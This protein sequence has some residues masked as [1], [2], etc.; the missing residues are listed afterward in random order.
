MNPNQTDAYKYLGLAQQARKAGDKRLARQHAE[1]AARLAPELEDVWLMMGA[2]ASPRASVVFMEK[3]LQIN[4][5]SERVRQGLHWAVER[6]KN[7]PPPK[8][9]PVHLAPAPDPDSAPKLADKPRIPLMM[10]LLS[11]MFCLVVLVSAVSVGPSMAASLIDSTM[12]N[13]NTPAWAAAEIAK[14]TY[15]A[16]A[17]EIAAPTKTTAF[18]AT[19][20][21]TLFPTETI[22]DILPRVDT[23]T[24][25]LSATEE[26]TST[27]PARNTF[28]PIPTRT[29]S[30]IPTEAAS[31][32]LP[33]TDDN[34]YPTPTALPT[35]TAIPQA[36]AAP[37]ATGYVPPPASNGNGS[38]RW[39]DVD[40]THQMVYAYEGNTVVNSF[41]V[42]TGTWQHPTVT[43]QYHVYIKYRYK[44]MSGPGYSLPNVPYTMFFYQGYAIHGTYW[45]SNFGTPMSHGCVN[46]S[47]PDSEWVYN[48]ASVGTL[49]NVHY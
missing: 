41:L 16:A 24:P 21:P 19:A 7:A 27:V 8:P 31:A 48:W 14:P 47:I 44:H 15:S 43:G 32:T 3:A 28:T 29:P 45:H 30:I 42:S 39:I 17:A 20:L 10:I 4:P 23:P 9:V 37:Q 40:L 38:G 2:L 13:K 36:T 46:L 33:A 5:E 34:A 49:V 11:M 26:A 6:L 18:I 1:Q 22:T 12:G 25:A 35:D